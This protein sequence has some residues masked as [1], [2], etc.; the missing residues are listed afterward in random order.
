MSKLNT[1]SIYSGSI[2]IKDSMYHSLITIIEMI[3]L[4]KKGFSNN[5]TEYYFLNKS[6]VKYEIERYF[7][8]IKVLRNPN[9]S[10][11]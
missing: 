7:M 9:E 3:K 8:S 1:V 4:L 11:G 5:K 10:Y 2:T 6:T